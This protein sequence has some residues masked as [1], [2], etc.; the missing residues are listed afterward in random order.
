MEIALKNQNNMINR[1]YQILD[2]LLLEEQQINWL[3]TFLV[4]Q[5][6]NLKSIVNDF[7]RRRVLNYLYCLHGGHLRLSKNSLINQKQEFSGLVSVSQ[8]MLKKLSALKP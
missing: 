8:S 3:H 4:N 2:K 1:S 7:T 5:L 6:V